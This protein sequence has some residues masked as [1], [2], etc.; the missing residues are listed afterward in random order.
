MAYAEW[1]PYTVY[2]VSDIVNYNGSDYQALQTNQNVV[3]TTLAPNWA[4]FGLLN[5]VDSNTNATF[6]PTF[7]SGVG[8]AIT[9]LNIDSLTTPISLN[10]ST[11]TI[12]ATTFSGNATTA[13]RST[14]LA[15]GLGG[16]IPYQSA[17]DTTALLANG[18]SGQYLKSNGTT[19]APSWD[20]LP[21]ASTPTLSQVLTAGNSA[22]SSSINLNSNS[23][24]SGASITATTFVGALTG[25][26]STATS[27]TTATTATTATNLAGGLGGSIPYQSAVNTT[28]LLANG[29]AGQVLTSAGTTLAPTWATPSAPSK[30]YV[31]LRGVA[32]ANPTVVSPSLLFNTGTFDI[33]VGVDQTSGLTNSG[34]N[35]WVMDA[36]VGRFYSPSATQWLV[37]LHIVSGYNANTTVELRTFNSGNTLLER[38][39]AIQFPTA[40]FATTDY[41]QIIPMAAG[42]YFQFQMVSGSLN[43]LSFSTTIATTLQVREL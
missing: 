40:N 24:T 20:T 19:V 37:I 6:F 27:A 14:N 16:S 39:T 34:T 2:V 25:N 43:G 42:D 11:A 21:V 41:S 38:R 26:A 22:G 10:P 12:T 33:P 5:I 35:G 9:T 1:S 17:V 30:A 3:P 8:A 29:T 28:A 7:V 31:Y 36:S 23:I 13:T 15:G 4:V 18:T 32:S